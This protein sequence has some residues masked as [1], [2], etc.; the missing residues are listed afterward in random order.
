MRFALAADPQSLDPLFAHP[1]A[2]SVEQQVARLSFEPFIDVDQH[3]VSVPVLLERIPTVANGGVS[4]DGRVI[5]YRLRAGVRW[6]DG[7]PVGARDVIWTL[8]AIL[9]DRNPVRSR[10]GYDRVA[11]AEAL[12]DRTVRIT[13]RSPW[14]PAVATLFSYGTAPQ[15][16]LPA[17]LLEREAHRRGRRAS[18]RPRSAARRPTSARGKRER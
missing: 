17:H 9:D 15:Y 18:A 7:V 4:R 5:T 13:L 8:H 6:Q 3:G 11:K 2:N 1:D 12:D 14:A 10:A 16:V